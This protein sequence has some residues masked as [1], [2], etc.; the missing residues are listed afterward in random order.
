MR[1]VSDDLRCT[2][3][4]CPDERVILC[5]ELMPADHL[6]LWS[7]RELVTARMEGRAVR[8]ALGG[9]KGAPD[10]SVTLLLRLLI[11]EVV[12]VAKRGLVF[13]LPH[14]QHLLPDELTLLAAI[15]RLQVGDEA[16]AC[17]LLQK[18][19]AN[20]PIN[21]LREAAGHLAKALRERGNLVRVMHLLPPHMLP[22]IH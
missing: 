15:D 2:S 4:A 18:L 22:S 6:L 1:T 12:S 13:G 8:Q 17:A 10:R 5:V 11:A 20:G 21:G 19:C 3:E 16:R 7:F 9:L 14:C